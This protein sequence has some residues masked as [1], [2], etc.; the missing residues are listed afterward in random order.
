[1]RHF[2][3]SKV[4]PKPNG[5]LAWL[6]HKETALIVSLCFVAISVFFMAWSVI[7]ANSP[8]TTASE[9]SLFSDPKFLGNLSQS[10][11]S[12]LSIYLIIAATVHNRSVGL[13]YQSWFWL[14]LCGSSLSSVL[15]LSLYSASPLFSMIFSWAAAFAQVIVPLLLIMKIGESGAGKRDDVE[16]H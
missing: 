10:V 8:S 5:L 4:R 2:E 13:H 11:L 16:R 1:M 7:R 15:G 3:M 14:C 12:N 9:H 6:I